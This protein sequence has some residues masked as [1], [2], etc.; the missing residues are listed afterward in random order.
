MQICVYI[1]IHVFICVYIYMYMSICIELIRIDMYCDLVCHIFA[2]EPLFTLL[3]MGMFMPDPHSH[4]GNH[5]GMYIIVAIVNP[6]I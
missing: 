2:E 1:Y 5:H 3:A 6:A 4:P